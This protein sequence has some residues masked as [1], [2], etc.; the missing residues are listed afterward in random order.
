MDGVAPPRRRSDT[1]HPRTVQSSLT[2][3][4]GSLAM[5][6]QKPASPGQRPN[7]FL[8]PSPTCA[9]TGAGKANSRG[10]SSRTR[11]S[12]VR[13]DAEENHEA[14]IERV[15]ERNRAIPDRRQRKRPDFPRRTRIG[16]R[17]KRRV[18]G[19]KT[20]RRADEIVRFLRV[21]NQRVKLPLKLMLADDATPR[22]CHAVSTPPPRA[23]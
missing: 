8:S 10:A 3:G 11:S 4:Q 6:G 16:E 13:H 19:K 1:I 20:L 21:A 22:R 18:F 12:V 9:R 14:L 7:N 17:A 2:Y 15:E 23:P 5:P